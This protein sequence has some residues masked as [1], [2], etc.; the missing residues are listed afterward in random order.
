MRS[1]A[2]RPVH[3]RDCHDNDRAQ[4]DQGEGWP[5]GTGQAAGERH[6]GL[7]NDGYSRDSFYRFRELY[8]KGGDLVSSDIRNCPFD[9]MR[10]RPP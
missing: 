2:P 6:P 5:V 1:A 7:P 9:D 3:R 8:A 10:N 4:G